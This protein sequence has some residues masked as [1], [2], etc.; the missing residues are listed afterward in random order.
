MIR[1]HTPL[2]PPEKRY[3]SDLVDLQPYKLQQPDGNTQHDLT[4]YESEFFYLKDNIII[5]YAPTEGETTSGTSTTRCELRENNEWNITK[6]EHSFYLRLRVSEKTNTNKVIVSQIHNTNGPTGAP[7]L[8]TRW[9]DGILKVHYKKNAQGDRG[10]SVQIG[11]PEHE[12]FTLQYDIKDG[13]C[14]LKY[15]EEVKFERNF[16]YWDYDCYFKCPE[17][18]QETTKG[19]SST[20]E[21]IQCE[22]RHG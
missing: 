9:E 17:Y 14:Q 12:W 8:H 13:V 11:T 5:F 7:L 2:P 1:S 4:D 6:N 18:N 22:L 20:V 21:M 3:P 10:N 16:S 15:N 19:K